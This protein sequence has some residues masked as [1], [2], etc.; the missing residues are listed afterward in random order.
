MSGTVELCKGKTT[1]SGA[2]V[3]S[4]TF[5]GWGVWELQRVVR[6]PVRVDELSS[7]VCQMITEDQT[8]T[9][10]AAAISG[11]PENIDGF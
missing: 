5:L 2:D 3:N 7:I 11:T 8:W 10:A 9:S 4:P 6:R 1:L